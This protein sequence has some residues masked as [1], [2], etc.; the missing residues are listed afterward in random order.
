MYME[1]IK[2]LKVLV[3]NSDM[4]QRNLKDTVES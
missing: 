3:D 2:L 1:K 4:E